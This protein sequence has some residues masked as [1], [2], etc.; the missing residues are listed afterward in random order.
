MDVAQ[1]GTM[2]DLEL[3]ERI[4]AACPLEEDRWSSQGTVTSSNNFICPCGITISFLGESVG[5]EVRE[6]L[7]E[8]VFSAP[9]LD[10]VVF[11]RQ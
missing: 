2:L 9:G 10:D 8:I 3:R 11:R 5:G 6:G 1:N 4:P 7:D